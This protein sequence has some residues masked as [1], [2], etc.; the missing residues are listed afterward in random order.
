[1]CSGCGRCG[2]VETGHHS[3]VTS[4]AP[5]VDLV[6]VASPRSGLQTNIIPEPARVPDLVNLQ[7]PSA[8]Q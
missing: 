4:V 6:Q 8:C 7:V 1:M 2:K 5:S 3:V